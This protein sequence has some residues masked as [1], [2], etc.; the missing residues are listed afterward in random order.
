L[1]VSLLLAVALAG[2]TRGTQGTVETPIPTKLDVIFLSP[3]LNA[4]LRPKLTSQLQPGSRTVSHRYGIGDWGSERT[5]TLDVRW[6]RNHI[7][8]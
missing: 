2:C 6:T 4:R 8:L 5:G 7:F 3:D 1:S